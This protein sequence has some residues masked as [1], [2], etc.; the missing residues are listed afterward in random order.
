MKGQVKVEFVLAVVAFAVVAF[1]V[2]TQLNSSFNI[3][4]GDNR[5]DM[6][7]ARAL[8]LV[9][10]MVE[11]TRWLSD[12]RP[13]SINTANLTAIDSRRDQFEQCLDLTPLRLGGYRMTVANSTH[14]LLRC[15][16]VTAGSGAV[17]VSRAVWI[18]RDWGTITVEMW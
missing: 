9:N 11:D 2:A 12:G 4:A 8:G 5:A 13:Y 18:E 7:H 17:S 14:T 15:G 6:L 10:L 16:A 1:A 3:V